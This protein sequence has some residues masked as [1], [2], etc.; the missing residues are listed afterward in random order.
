[1]IGRRETTAQRDAQRARAVVRSRSAT[2]RHLSPIAKILGS[3]ERFYGLGGGV[4]RG[5]G[6]GASLGVG[7]GLGVGAARRSYP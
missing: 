7:V 2:A 5:L 1:M 3:G 4:G 6:L